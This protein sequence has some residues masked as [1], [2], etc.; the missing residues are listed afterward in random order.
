MMGRE[1]TESQKKAISWEEGSVVVLAGP[2]SG[3]TAVLTERIIRILE[4][5]PEDSFRILALT[6]T[7]KAAAEMVERISDRVKDAV[8]RVFIGTFHKFCAEILRNHGSYVGICPD[9]EIYSSTDDL[10]DIVEDLK[11]KYCHVFPEAD[12]ENL[13]ILNAIQYFEKNL[14]LIEEDVD[15][16]MPNTAYRKELKWFYFEYLRTLESIN[17]LDFDALIL[18]AYKLF[19]TQAKIARIY[20]STYRYINID[21]FQ[22]TNY[23]QY[24]LIKSLA[25]NNNNNLFI[26][27]D[28]DQVIYGWNGANHKRISEFKEEY[29]A[30]LIQLNQNFRCPPE[31]IKLANNLIAH[32]SGRTMGKKPLEAMKEMTDEKA[33]LYY[34]CF[35]DETAEAEAVAELILKLQGEN[36]GESVCVL[37]RNNRLLENAFNKAKAKGINCEKSKRKD[38]F[39]TTYILWMYLLLKLA[40]RRTDEKILGQIVAIMD[41]EDSEKRMLDS[42]QLILEAQLSNGDLLKSLIPHIKGIIDDATFFKSLQLNLCEGKDFLKFIDDAFVWSEKRIG[43]IVSEEH[44]E[45]AIQEFNLEKRA[46]KDFQRKLGYTYALDEMTISTYMQEF[47]MT[48]KDVEPEVGAIQFLTIHASKGKEFD[49][50]ILMGMV[51]DV[52]PSFQSIEKGDGSPEME[53]ERRNCFVAITRAKKRL[54]LTRAAKYFGWSKK[55]SRFLEEMLRGQ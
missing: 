54:Y 53:E 49:H 55:A 36:E 38:K 26:V 9:Y 13:K 8:S 23:G 6:F 7:N 47:A 15:K 32:N 22:D 30:G 1:Y 52:L 44:R 4:E 18:Y 21:E 3:K 5:T 48:S 11:R 45:Q 10:N 27:A 17:V 34:Q 25:G 50:V 2:G 24:M 46:W 29:K 43:L 35:S 41:S 16:F 12:I 40:N 14:C 31:V 28:D 33:N 19:T 20:R 39:E 51:D 42:K 37:A